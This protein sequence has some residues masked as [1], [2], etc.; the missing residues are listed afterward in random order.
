MRVGCPRLT[1][2]MTRYRRRRSA[3]TTTPARRS[4]A[5][6][7]PRTPADD[8]VPSRPDRSGRKIL[9]LLSARRRVAAYFWVSRRASCSAF[10]ARIASSTAAR[11][12]RSSSRLA[13]LRGHGRGRPPGGLVVVGLLELGQ[14]GVDLGDPGAIH[15][16]ATP[17][18][19]R[20]N[21]SQRAQRL[22][23]PGALLGVEGHLARQP[24]GEE[25]HHRARAP[26]QRAGRDV[27]VA[28]VHEEVGQGPGDLVVG[29]PGGGDE[30]VDKRGSPLVRKGFP[31]RPVPEVVPAACPGQCPEPDRGWRSRTS[32]TS[33]GSP[34]RR[35]R[36]PPRRAARR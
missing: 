1:V 20:A 13:E 12:V 17:R 3:S 6:G 2:R 9:E 29:E 31:L 7:S 24:V 35:S 22:G 27:P 33:A 16:V 19:S 26:T 11:S 21:R 32:A 18:P 25:Q 23:Q 34:A 5:L 30:V 36:T 4:C 28:V 15:S 8:P 10:S 14:G